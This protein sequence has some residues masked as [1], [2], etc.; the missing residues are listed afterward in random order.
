MSK[1]WFDTKSKVSQYRGIFTHPPKQVPSPKVVDGPIIGNGDVGV[2]ISGEPELQRLWISKNDF[3]KAKRLYPNGSPC[4]L[5]GMDIRIPSLAGGSYYC[6]QRLYEAEIYSRFETA[7]SIVMMRSWVSAINNI[8][9]IE[10][11]SQGMPVPVHVELWAQSGH[12]SI[13]EKGQEGRVHWVTRRFTGSDLDWPTQG[14]MA[15]TCLPDTGTEFVLEDGQQ[16]VI[17]VS[18]ATNHDSSDYL[19]E[20]ISSAANVSKDSLHLTRLAHEQWWNQ[21]WSKSHIDISDELLE[22]FW[23]GSHYIMACCS[24]NKSFP[25]GLLGN[26]ITTDSPAWAGDYHLNYNYQASWWGTYSSN[27][28][29]LTDPYD[30]PILEYI[31]NGRQYAAEYLNCRGVYYDVGI[32]PKGLPTALCETPYEDGHMFCG[33]KS[34]ASYCA[35]NMLMRFYHTY[36]LDYAEQIAYPFLLEVANFWED[37]LIMENNRYVIYNDSIREVDVWT[38]DHEDDSWAD[39]LKDMNPILSLGFIRAVFNGLLD[40]SAEL[41]KDAE[42]RAH[43]SHVLEHLSDFP[44]C[45][46]EGKTV[47]RL[48][49]QGCE[50][51]TGNS[52]EI[53]HVFPAGAIG[54]GSSPQLLE[55]ARNT[56]S[57]MNRWTDYNGFPTIFTAAARVGYD[58]YMIIEQLRKQCAE[59]SFPNLFIFFGG[60]GIECCSGVPAAM[61]EMLLQSHEQC[62]R[63]FPVWPTERNARFENLRA[64]GA[65]LVSSELLEGE[66][67][68]VEIKSEKGR[69]CHVMNPWS[70]RTCRVLEGEHD[71]QCEISFQINGQLISFETEAGKVY[72]I[73]P[74]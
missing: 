59:H 38:T 58:P 55:T 29:E 49:E 64:V 4:L 7:E 44:T 32:G 33:Q 46:R 17:A 23:Y 27:H 36:D 20:A 43:W 70:G 16:I 28:I 31:P 48:T 53:Q 19:G 60:G 66:V 57:V 73:S 45:E 54:L 15:M 69:S 13:S 25:P 50:F 10:L 18:I 5:G 65:F 34:N 56:L 9:L 39:G 63:L 26:W 71:Q 68:Y 12:E 22:K 40:I 61:N 6:E 30:T 74:N 35:I 67:A 37:Y 72:R 24:R 62:I 21:F 41:G 3:W 1:R 11:S 2:V 14:S 8:L 47:F 52:L 42:R 51:G